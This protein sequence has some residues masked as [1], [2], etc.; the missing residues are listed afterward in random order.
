MRYF[1]A[2]IIFLVTCYSEIISYN[3]IKWFVVKECK[4]YPSKLINEKLI[5]AI[6]YYESRVSNEHYNTVAVSKVGCVG[7]MQIHQ[8]TLDEFKR[9]T[10]KEYTLKDMENK[11]KNISVGI[12]CFSR[13]LKKAKG[14]LWKALY[15]YNGAAKKSVCYAEL[16][17]NRA[18]LYY[19]YKK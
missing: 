18:L 3:S 4:Y 12:W 1:I 6:M 19:I 17:I 8:D 5:H 2:V 10:G 7:L 13:K 11:Y 16:V 15:F 14:V 9:L